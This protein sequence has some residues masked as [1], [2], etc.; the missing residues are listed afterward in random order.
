V[1]K[2]LAPQQKFDRRGSFRQVRTEAED[3]SVENRNKPCLSSYLDG[4]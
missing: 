3:V 4:E 2:L 1:K